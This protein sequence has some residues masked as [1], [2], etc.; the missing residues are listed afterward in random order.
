MSRSPR[1]RCSNGNRNWWT[2]CGRTS[3]RYQN[4]LKALGFNIANSV[5]PIVPVMTKNDPTTIE[6]TRLCRAEG[7]LVIPVCYPAV[8]AD[9]PRLR[10]CVSAIHTDDEID[11]ALGVLARAGRQTKLIP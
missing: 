4:G 7:L 9:A 6:M 11:F 8:P 1:W 10:T 3:S 5:T 2:A